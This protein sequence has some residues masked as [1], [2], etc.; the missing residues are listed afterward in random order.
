MTTLKDR[1]SAL[2]WNEI[3]LLFMQSQRSLCFVYSTGAQEW[4]IVSPLAD[5]TS[6]TTV[7]HYVSMTSELHFVSTEKH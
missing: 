2:G 4:H 7:A 1:S 3:K 5:V 6:P